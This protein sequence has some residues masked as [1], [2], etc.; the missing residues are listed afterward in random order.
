MQ[1]NNGNFNNKHRQ[2]NQHRQNKHQ[3]KRCL[4]K[5]SL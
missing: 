3:I 5:Q 1:K 2:D 4:L